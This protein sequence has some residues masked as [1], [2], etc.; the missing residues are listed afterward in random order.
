M[1]LTVNLNPYIEKYVSI[2]H[3]KWGEQNRTTLLKRDVA[4]QGLN[5]ALA[6]KH[7]GCEPFCIGFNYTENGRLIT[8]ALE[9]A[10]VLYDLVTVPGTLRT[11]LK[12]Q[13]N[14]SGICTELWEPG[15]FVTEEAVEDLRFRIRRRAPRCTSAV[16]IGSVPKGVGEE[17]YQVLLADLASVGVKTVLDA[18]GELLRKGLPSCPWM[19]RTDRET[20]RKLYNGRKNTDQ[21]ILQIAKKIVSDG[22]S[23]VWVSDWGAEA[24]VVGTKESYR[25]HWDQQQMSPTTVEI[26]DATVAGICMAMDQQADF[27]EV[28]GYGAAATA[29]AIEREGARM[30]T[31]LAFER[32]LP[33]ITIEEL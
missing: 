11:N 31:R 29:S 13:E 6:A 24:M 26:S 27:Y 19:V 22:V 23:Y 25:I 9:N 2:D 3:L 18:P 10:G 20:L 32:W 21:E 30:C 14:A 5:V 28:M 7:L 15:G 16:L 4:G 8:A 12:I 33:Q 1:I 17:I